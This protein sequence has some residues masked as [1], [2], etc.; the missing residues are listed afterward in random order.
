MAINSGVLEFYAGRGADHAGRTLDTI[1]DLSD[2]QLE[3]LHD[4]IQWL[5]PMAVPS[6]VN[7]C[8]PIVDRET[9]CAFQKCRRLRANLC[10]SCARMLR[11]YG[12]YCGAR[13]P[14]CST[15][16]PTSTFGSRSAVWLTPDNHNHL[17]LTRILSSLRLLG[18]AECSLRLL[19][20]L[21]D[22]ASRNPGRV[23]DR[24][25][26][27]WTNSQQGDGTIWGA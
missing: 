16:Q 12:L 17:R 19:Q 9:Q 20:C 10:R 2:S 6:A 24:T 4:Y 13:E 22:I 14:P 27:F 23:T 26:M 1:L 15:I 3:N 21:E 25:R 7:L 18:L 8:A 11:F 5:F